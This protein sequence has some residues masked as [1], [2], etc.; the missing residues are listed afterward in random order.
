MN[1]IRST[2]SIPGIAL[3]GFGS[4]EDIKQSLAAGFAV[5]LTKPVDFRRLERA[6]HEIAAGAAA[7]DLV[8]G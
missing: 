8:G 7:E 1:T 5:H 3:S 4:A 2:R 6:I